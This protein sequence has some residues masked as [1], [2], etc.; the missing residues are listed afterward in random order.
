MKPLAFYE[1]ERNSTNGK[2]ICT[3]ETHTCVLL[4]D[5]R[6]SRS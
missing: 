1:K 3:S 2:V 6:L 4:I 5:E